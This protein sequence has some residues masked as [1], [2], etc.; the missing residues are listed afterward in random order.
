MIQLKKLTDKCWMLNDHATQKTVGM[1]NLKDENY[2]LVGKNQ[3]FPRMS[4]L[5][6]EIFND[7][8]YETPD[9]GTVKSN[10]I[11]QIKGFPIRHENVIICGSEIINEK[12]IEIYKLKENSETTY[13]AGWFA[14]NFKKGLVAAHNPRVNT[15]KQNEFIGPFY[16]EMDMEIE[17]KRYNDRK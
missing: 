2:Y 1:V 6:Q 4:L 9:G 16:S 14:L 11:T 17:V 13:A 3:A 7:D 12:N 15:L 10:H 5:I 8:I